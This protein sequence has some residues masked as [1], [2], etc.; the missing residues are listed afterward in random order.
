MACLG[1]FSCNNHLV[2]ALV[3]ACINTQKNAILGLL[4]DCPHREQAQY[5]GDSL[6][7]SHLLIYSFPDARLLLRKVLRDFADSQLKEGY[8]PFVSPLDWEPKS[9]HFLRSPE[10]DLLYPVLLRNLWFYYDD[11]DSVWEFYPH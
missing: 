1:E 8:F 3:D 6:M 9:M 10:Y 5:L 7:Q 4:V 11:M 2:N